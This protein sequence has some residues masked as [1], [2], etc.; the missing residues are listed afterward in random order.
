[1][2]L[3]AFGATIVGER[4]AG[5]LEYTNVRPFV[6]PQ[7]GLTVG[8][9]TKRNYYDTPV[10]SIGIPVHIYLAPH[11]MRKPAEELLPIIQNIVEDYDGPPT[12]E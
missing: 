10:E 6:L 5:Y 2:M 12:L 1:A 11:L 8:I 3:S 9:P 7:T 4:T